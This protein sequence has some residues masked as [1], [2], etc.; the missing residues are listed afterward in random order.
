M[1]FPRCDN[2]KFS[3]IEWFGDIPSHWTMTRLGHL[4]SD[5]NDVNHEMPKAVYEGVPFLSAKDL[6]DDGTL[7]FTNDVKM[8]SE[9]DF[10]NLSKKIRP[11]RD[12]II[13][14]RI[15]T[16]GKARLVQTDQQFSVS[17]SCCVVRVSE[18][19]VCKKF[20]CQLLDGEMLLTEARSSDANKRNR[21]T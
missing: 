13:Y 6:L 5:I 12:D 4:C 1:S 3:G 2:R 15:G 20:I 8:I 9:E 17:Y 18:E 11:Q 16:L 7:N 14:S 21:R 10:E 19:T